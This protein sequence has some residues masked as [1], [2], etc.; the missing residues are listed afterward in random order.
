MNLHLV[1]IIILTA[2]AVLTVSYMFHEMIPLRIIGILGYS[3]KLV[4]VLYEGLGTPGMPAEF[5]LA[6]TTVVVNL[7]YVIKY[8]IEKYMLSVPPEFKRIYR[9]VFSELTVSE[10]KIFMR[11]GKRHH[12]INTEVIENNTEIKEIMLILKGCADVYYENKCVAQLSM[13]QFMGEM[14]FLAKKPTTGNVM[15]D[16]ELEY[17]AW[18][19]DTL[20]KIH[21]DHPHLYVK[22]MGILGVDI[23]NKLVSKEASEDEGVE[24]LDLPDGIDTQ[25]T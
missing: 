5:V 23:I 14:S 22:I 16:G 8:W 15:A 18:T 2:G 10:F 17:I 9:K 1:D 12:V 3:I 21:H 20:G 19:R 25:I 6:F 11:M 7:Y 4:A 13:G 24:A